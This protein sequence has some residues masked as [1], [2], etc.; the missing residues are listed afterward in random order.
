MLK[1]VKCS[2]GGCDNDRGHNVRCESCSCCSHSSCTSPSVHSVEPLPP[3]LCQ[4]ST[5]TPSLHWGCTKAVYNHWTGLVDW[6]DGLDWWTDT[7]N[8]FYVFQW[9][10]LACGVVWKPP[11]FVS[12]YI[13]GARANNSLPYSNSTREGLCTQC[14]MA[15]C[16]MM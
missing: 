10:S 3:I 6:T 5:C 11:S 9:L 8:Q 15:F 16:S 7:K 1:N 13:H 14:V 12:I 4:N 2:C